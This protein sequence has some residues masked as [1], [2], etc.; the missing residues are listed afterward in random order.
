MTRLY[1]LDWQE[2]A[3]IYAKNE[4]EAWSELWNALR[5]KKKAGCYVHSI[6]KN[7]ITEEDGFG[8]GAD[9]IERCVVCG[10]P[11][12]VTMVWA[13]HPVYKDKAYCE[14]CIEELLTDELKNGIV[15]R[16]YYP[17]F[18]SGFDQYMYVTTDRADFERQAPPG[19]GYIYAST[20]DMLFYYRIP[21]ND[22]EEWWGGAYRLRGDKDKIR[23]F[24]K[25]FPALEECHKRYG[26]EEEEE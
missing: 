23:R 26:K 10:D 1:K 25:E 11:V 3:Y 4:D 16:K 14:S 19:E 24:L 6:C 2:T 5:L 15:A 18:C 20:D 12:G 21:K 8:R 9:K 7:K 13:G 17:N 22:G